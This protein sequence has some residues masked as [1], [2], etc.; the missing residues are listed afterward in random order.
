MTNTTDTGWEKRIE[1]AYAYSRTYPAPEYPDDA[2]ESGRDKSYVR[3]LN[4]LL[5]V[6]KQVAKEEYE[7][8]RKDAVGFMRGNIEAWVGENAP[9]RVTIEIERVFEAALETPS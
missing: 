9:A 1:E 2:D 3:D 4:D 5:E 8:G 7:R 6:V